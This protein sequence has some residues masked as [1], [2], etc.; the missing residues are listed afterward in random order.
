MAIANSLDFSL[1][2]SINSKNRKALQF[3][4]YSHC[5]RRSKS[6]FPFISHFLFLNLNPRAVRADSSACSPPVLEDNAPVIELALKLQDFQPADHLPEDYKE[7]NALICSLLKDSETAHLGYEYYEKAKGKPN[8]RPRRNT[9]KLLVRYLIRS[10]NW[11]LLFSF[12]ED[13]QVFRVLPD[14]STC[15]RLISACLK[16][17]K[18]RVV[19]N[20]LEVFLVNDVETAVLAFGFAMKGYNQLHMYCSTNDLYQR[21][22]SAGLDLDPACYFHIME[23]HLKMKH[24]EKCITIF[25]D[26]ENRRMIEI[27]NPPPF[28]SQIYW[29]LCESLGKTG[30]PFEAL[31]Y[32]REMSKKGILEDHFLYSSLISSFASSGE[33]EMAEELL[34][35]AESKKMLRDPALFLKLVLRYVQEGMMEKTLDVVA[36]MRR[37]GIRVSDCIFCAIINGFSKK[38]GAKA[39]ARVY[40]ELVLQGCEP[41][42]VTYA[43]ILSAYIR[44][45]RYSKAES[46]FAEMERKGFDN[47]I[48]AYSSM[49][50]AYA[51]MG[52]TRDAMRLVAKMKERGCEPNVWT[53]NSLLDMNG[54]ALNLRFVEKTWKEMKRRK[55]IP[56]RVSYTTVISAYNR[57]REFETCVKYYEEF[58]LTGGKMDRAMAGTMVAVFSKMNRVEEVIELLRDMKLQGTELD[59]RFYRSAMNAL[60]DAGLQSQARWLQETFKHS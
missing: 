21:M 16:A 27:G 56:D 48:V 9:L 7:S 55:I 1:T 37:V 18:L 26:F 50:A 41:G 40:E 4:H 58:K 45:G 19:N 14:R 53:Y 54:R 51:K 32:F 38:R 34:Q 22:K 24:Y 17:R 2:S 20:L 30:R 31:E 29:I 35:E 43:S 44:L 11:G 25:Q 60:R 59:A 49:V 15:C 52:R 46:V 23:A 6:P 5:K 39:A 8:F 33:L 28:C 47:C 10:K 3:S 12:C 57:A 36:A 13:L 42:Q